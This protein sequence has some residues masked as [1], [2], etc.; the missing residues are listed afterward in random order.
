VLDVG[1]GEQELEASIAN[2]VMVSEC[3]C[4]LALL[5]WTQRRY[6]CEA[7]PYSHRFTMSCTRC[8]FFPTCCAQ[9]TVLAAMPVSKQTGYDREQTTCATQSMSRTG[10]LC[11]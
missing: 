11:C 2:E 7:F 4:D 3:V 6:L 9:G 8:T 5:S 1:G 10:F